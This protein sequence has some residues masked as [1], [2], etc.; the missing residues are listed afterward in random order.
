MIKEFLNNIGY[1]DVDIGKILVSKRI[2]NF[3]EL[4]LFNNMP[5]ELLNINVAD[6][7]LYIATILSIVSGIQYYIV[8]KDA[9]KEK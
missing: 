5:F 3:S 1:S 7:L 4:T 8:N 2:N 6:G 9:F